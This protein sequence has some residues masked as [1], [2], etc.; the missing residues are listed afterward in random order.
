VVV[1][2][3]LGVLYWGGVV[4]FSSFFKKHFALIITD[5]RQGVYRMAWLGI[6]SQNH[7]AGQ[8]FC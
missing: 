1:G 5:E 4:L 3:I 8:K 7:W 2:D 6:E